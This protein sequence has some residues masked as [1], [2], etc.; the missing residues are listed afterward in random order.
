MITIPYQLMEQMGMLR[1]DLVVFG[2]FSENSFCVRRL[3]SDEIK[4]LK[5]PP[6]KI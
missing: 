1:G 6:L 3:N 2:T 5:P 4:F